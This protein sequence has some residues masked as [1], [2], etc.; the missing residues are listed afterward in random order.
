MNLQENIR[1]GWRSV[2]ANWLRSVLT[3]LIVAIGISALV[4]ILTAIDNIQGSVNDS[5]AELGANA[6]DIEAPS[7]RGRRFGGPRNNFK[8]YPPIR[9]REAQAFKQ[10]YRQ[11]AQVSLSVVVS[12]TIEA[13]YGAKKTNPNIELIGVNEFYLPVMGL[14]L[15]QG[16]NFST[17][18]LN[19]G[20]PVA[21]IGSE[22]AEKLFGNE[23]PLDKGVI[24]RSKK[25]RVVGVLAEKGQ[26][27]G[28]LGDRSVFVPLENARLMVDD[29]NASY[30][31]KVSLLNNPNFDLAIGEATSLMRRIRRDAPGMDDSF[32]IN[33]SETLAD[34]LG[35]ITSYLRIGGGVVGFITLL[36]ASIGLMNIMLVSVTERTR[37][38]GVRKALGATPFRIRQQFLVEAVVICLLGGVLGI[39]LGIMIGNVVASF[40]GAETFIV[41]WAWVL[42]GLVLCIGV[43]I[44]S[45]YYPAYKASKLDPI[46]SLRFE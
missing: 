1:E 5:F 10:H 31:L 11:A 41:P 12:G 27:Q 16:R 8:S 34:R 46:E 24:V 18:E 45:G 30:A 29:E 39:L 7:A 32:I 25:Y 28:N 33:R 19:L 2:K 36:G 37:E 15:Q 9:Y 17:P 22:I 43:G 26:S 40:L 42:T 13:K 44:S 4:G 23:S 21:L 14:D 6:F 20:T 3:A 38:I 35:S